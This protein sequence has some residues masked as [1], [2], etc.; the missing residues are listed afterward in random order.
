MRELSEQLLV[1]QQLGAPLG[2]VDRGG[3]LEAA[4]SEVQARPVEVAVARRHAEHLILARGAALDALDDPLQH[5]HVL[6]IARPDE[7]AIRSLAEPV[8]A[9]DLRQRVAGLLEAAPQVDPVLEVVAHVIA[10]KRQ[11]GERI[12]PHHALGACGCRRGFRAHRRG[13]VDALV[14]VVRLG[15]QRHRA[16]TPST[17]DECI[18]RHAVRVGPFRVERGVVGGRHGKT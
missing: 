1:Q 16:G 4:L 2:R 15:H 17:K 9:I 14:P 6:A 5:P 8:D 12:A 10:D 7:V 18:D 13:H 3:Q 11:H